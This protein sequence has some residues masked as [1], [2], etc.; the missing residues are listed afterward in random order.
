M[1]HFKTL[2]AYL[3]YLELPRPE[4]PMFAIYSALGDGFLPCVKE[5]SPPISN[6][7]YSISFKRNISGDLLYGR[8]QYDFTNGALFFIGPRQVLEWEDSA[9]LEQKGFSIHFHE[10][11][12]KG[13]PLAQQIKK[14]GYF[15]Y[16]A[17]E[18][19]HLSPKEEKQL[20][21]IVENIELEYQNN[22]DS[23]SKDLIVSHLNTLLKYAQRFYERQFINRTV[24]STSLLEQ[25][26]A[27][28]EQYFDSG[29]L[30][31]QGIPNIST[32]A[33]KLSVSQRYLSDT[34]KRETGKS[35]TEHLQLF[36]IDE[37]KN[38]LLNPQK[39]VAEVAYDL[40]FEYPA[41][42]SRLFKKKEGMSP[43]AY[44][45]QYSVN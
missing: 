1:Q 13:T 11:F 10:D 22:Q 18:A 27:E 38:I 8:T 23:F 44:R 20:E 19:L 34:L 2:S 36:L 43:T 33:E 5:S 21:L 9:V 30:Q 25:F 24:L 39:T 45:E 35:S 14:Y 15:S 42:F 28:L 26:N 29:Q 32:I 3:A 31:E 4:H 12:L 37:A 40:G 6:D 41:Y 7:C 16:S 17:N